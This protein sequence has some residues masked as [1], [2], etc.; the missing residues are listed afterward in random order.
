MLPLVKRTHQL[1]ASVLAELRIQARAY[2]GWLAEAHRAEE[3]GDHLMVYSARSC[4]EWHR[5]KGRELAA[6]YQQ[7][8]R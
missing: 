2:L 8:G 4:A 7:Q 6:P 3:A 5:N 1:P